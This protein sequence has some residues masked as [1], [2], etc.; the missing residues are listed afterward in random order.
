VEPLGHTELPIIDE[1]V[2][3]NQAKFAEVIPDS[4]GG[5]AH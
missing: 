4:P 1:A 3:S 5:D 2:L